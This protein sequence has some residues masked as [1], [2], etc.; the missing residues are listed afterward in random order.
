MYGKPQDKLTYVS[1]CLLGCKTMARAG[2]ALVGREYD[3]CT[4]LSNIRCTKSFTGNKLG[5]PFH[6]FAFRNTYLC[7]GH[8]TVLPA[9]E[10][11]PL[12]PGGEAAI[13]HSVAKLHIL[14]G[15]AAGAPSALVVTVGSVPSWRNPTK[16]LF[17][18]ARLH[19][20]WRT[21]RHLDNKT[22]IRGVYVCV[23]VL[24]TECRCQGLARD[25]VAQVG[26]HHEKGVSAACAGALN[27]NK[28]RAQHL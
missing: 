19:T 5:S 22:R 13:H 23:C 16:W 21:S 17:V 14:H 6:T 10:G 15:P 7:T 11:A 18:Q 8:P 9:A 25:R 20:S 4:N 2:C 24:Q 12:T 28:V 26:R 3:A 27:K 1:V